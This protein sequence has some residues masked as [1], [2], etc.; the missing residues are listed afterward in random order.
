MASRRLRALASSCLRRCDGAR[1]QRRYLAPLRMEEYLPGRACRNSDTGNRDSTAGAKGESRVKRD[2]QLSGVDR[3]DFIRMLSG[4]AAAAGMAG[5]S[6]GCGGGS[7]TDKRVIVLGLDGLDP[8]LIQA[9]IDMGRAPNFKKLAE[10]GSFSKLGTT[11][12]A[13]SPVA[14]STFITGM[15]PGG[16]G[17]TD[18]VVRDPKTYMPVFSIF[19]NTEPDVVFSVGD[20]HLPI[21]GG[22]P[23]NRRHG[24]PVLEL[25]HRSRHP[26]VDLQDPDQLPGRG[27][28]HHG[29]LGDGHPRSHRCLRALQLLHLGSLRGLRRDGRRHRPVRRCQ[30][31]R[32]P[33]QPPRTGQRAQNPAGRQPRPHHQ[34][35]QDPVHRLSRPRCRR[36]PSRHP[37]P[38]HPA[39]TRPVLTLGLGGVR[40][41]ARHRHRPRQRPLP[42]QGGRPAL[43]ALCHARSTSTPSTRRVP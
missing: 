38:E 22:G 5:V 9:L 30:R 40:A 19:E 21:K 37:G 35:H 13:L 25:S 3:R 7:T 18:F 27:D 20:I 2:N 28:R 14:W 12:P 23:V 10:M 4:S 39:Q 29:D 24:H 31:Q 36:R 33:R 34:H 26:G 6:A 43:Q 1:H 41:A 11:M 8:T 15:S 32:R 42:G 17:I 16:H